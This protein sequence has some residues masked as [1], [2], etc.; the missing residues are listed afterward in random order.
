M[1]GQVATRISTAAPTKEGSE[2]LL[3]FEFI[4]QVKGE[5]LQERSGFSILAPEVR[6]GRRPLAI[7]DVH[8]L[9]VARRRRRHPANLSRVLNQDPFKV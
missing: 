2:S 5:P 8:A 3:R 7:L 4:R 1:L 6:Q 9:W